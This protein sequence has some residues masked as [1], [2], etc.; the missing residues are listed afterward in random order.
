MSK[1]I[2]ISE[3]EFRN[4]YVQYFKES[5]N[6]VDEWFSEENI[7]KFKSF[8]LS[9]KISKLH[10]SVDAAGHVTYKDKLK[11]DYSDLYEYVSIYSNDTNIVLKRKNLKEITDRTQDGGNKYIIFV[12][13]K[14]S[15]ITISF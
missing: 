15:V 9:H 10:I 5:S 2:E 12:T 8:I 13:K 4:R 3:A 14:D 1:K 7:T 6:N 11:I